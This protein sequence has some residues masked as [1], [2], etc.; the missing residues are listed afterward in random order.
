MLNKH[1]CTGTFYIP[2]R[3]AGAAVL[4]PGEIRTIAQEHEIG[5]HTLDH[6]YLD[7]VTTAVARAQIVDGKCVLE[8]W[9]GRSVN[10]F[11][12]PGGKHSRRV[13]GLVRAAAFS[14]ARTVECFSLQTYED[15]FRMPTTIQLNPY[16]P[17]QYIRNYLKR[18]HWR[19]R[20]SGLIAVTSRRDLRLRLTAILDLAWRRGGVFHLWGHSWELET[21]GLWPILDDFLKQ[22]AERIPQEARI[23]NLSLHHMSTANAG[24]QR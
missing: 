10:G 3:R 17:Q 24:T 12:Y 9:L 15:P 21:L 8:D 4:S 16:R 5:G 6:C 14:Y 19:S 18:G 1:G 7:Q 23:T 11:A 20:L 22:V 13:R 2:C